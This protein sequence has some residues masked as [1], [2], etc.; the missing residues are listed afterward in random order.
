MS[1]ISRILIKFLRPRNYLLFVLWR[2]KIAQILIHSSRLNFKLRKANQRGLFLD[3]GSNIGQGFEFFRKF[4]PLENFDFILFEPN[5]YCY[6]VLEQK[7]SNFH[8]KGVMLINAAVGTKEGQID[9][10]GLDETE[11]GIY[12][13]GGSILPEHNSRI[14][15]APRSSSLKVNS[16]NFNDFLRDLIGKKKYSTIVLKLDIEGGE[17]EILDSLQDEHLLTLFESIYVEFHSQ[18]MSLEKA[19]EFLNRERKFLQHAKRNQIR[20]VKWI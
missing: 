20:I 10:Y 1:R 13:V 11:G 2:L 4:Y 5:P 9:F 12:S 17:Y 19:L 6:K 8:T 18:Y 15:L 7:Y 3:C 16:I 14:Y